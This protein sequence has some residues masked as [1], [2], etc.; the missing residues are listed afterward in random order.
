MIDV[1]LQ[2]NGAN[3]RGWKNIEVSIGMEQISGSFKM[4]ASDRWHGQDTAWPIL[5]D[6]A[7]RV[8]IGSTTVITGYVDEAN[9]EY[10][11]KSHSLNITGR[12]A[13]GDLVDCS[14][15]YKSGQWS[16]ADLLKIAKDLCSPFGINV[17]ADVDVGKKFAKFALQEGE[18]VFEAIERA[19]RQRGVL[20]L[21]DGAGG[22]LITRAG[23]SRIDAALIKGENIERASGTFSHK[24]RYS[25]YIIKGQAPGGDV[26]AEPSHHAQLKAKSEDE[27]VRRY[28]PLIIYAEQGDGS[29]YKDRATWERNVRAGR[30]ARLQYT[31]TGWEYK[32]GKLWLPN[33]IVPAKD[34]YIGVDMDMLITRC[35]YTLDD[36]GSRTALELCRREAFDLVNLPNMKRASGL[37]K[38][39]FR[40]EKDS[41]IKDKD[42]RKW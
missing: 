19:A 36:N 8:L 31:V 16:G 1:T 18:T 34:S 13:T 35:T 40:S 5:A 33:R 20:L 10:D 29:T 39:T 17:Q 21:S 27:M 25:Q 37:G 28:R 9:P 11:A 14:A 24:E 30:S 15:I 42:K 22:L 38:T 32:P 6:D 2:V 26:F 4:V 7:C 23:E 3:Y 12:D 41:R